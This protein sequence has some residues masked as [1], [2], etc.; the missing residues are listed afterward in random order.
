[1]QNTRDYVEQ[2]ETK[3]VQLEDNR[4]KPKGL[5]LLLCELRERKEDVLARP[6]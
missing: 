4:V 2:K 1:M 5:R 3:A 6:Q